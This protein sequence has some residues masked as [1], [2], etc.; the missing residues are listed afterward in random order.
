M[1][2]Q[3]EVHVK[4]V[5]QPPG[6]VEWEAAGLRWLAA[7]GGAAVVP[8]L[9]VHG[10]RL[11]IERLRPASPTREHAA[12]FGRAL[13][14]THDAGA[15]AFGVGPDGWSGDGWFGPAHDPLPLV[16]TSYESWG[17][18]FAD[19]RIL[20]FVRLGVERGVFGPADVA[21]FEAVADRLRGGEFDTGEPPARLHGDLWSG[22]VFWTTAGAVLIDPAANGGD[23]ES[24]LALLQL[25]GAPHLETIL[26]AYDEAH[27]LADGWRD[28]VALHQLHPLLLHAVVFAGGYVRECLQVAARYR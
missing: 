19:A 20:P 15:S 14:A 12:A 1:S 10:D 11:E 4:V 18:M 27:P 24:D 25:F 7:A 5:R 3:P 21:T 17:A 16:L 22:N 8:V 6:Y 26:A 9:G 2:Q 13:T 28:R 23:R